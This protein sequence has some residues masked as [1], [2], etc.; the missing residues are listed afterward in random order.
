MDLFAAFDPDRCRLCGECFHRCPVLR[1]PVGEAVDEM[2]R[3]RDGRDTRAVLQRCQSCFACNLG[4]PEGAN[5]TQLILDRWSEAIRRDG[6]PARA[7][8]YVPHEEH[9]FRSYVV[10]RLPADEAAMV[11]GWADRS[12][13]AE[14]L[15]PGCNWITAPYLARTRALDGV[16]IR[17]TLADCCGETYYRMGLFDRVRQSAERLVAFVERLQV[18]RLIVPCTAGLNM[19]R[20]VM[21][22]FGVTLPAEVEHVVP[23]L[24]RRLDRGELTIR[25]RLELT[26]TIQE[27]C[28][29]KLFGQEFLD[30]P[31]AL[32]E[33]LGVRVV[34]QPLHGDRALCCGIAGGFSP[35]SAFHPAEITRATVRALT[36]ARRTGADAIATYCAGCAQ[37]LPTGQLADPRSRQPV[38]HLMELLQMALGEP[39]P[40]MAEKRRRAATVLAGVTRH[41]GP[42]LLSRRRLHL[43]PLGPWD[44]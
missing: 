36:S 6:L 11:R 40:S 18:E 42:A 5:P 2:R 38:Y 17:G 9:N 31:R 34:E 27:S 24:L 23:W 25:R 29:G 39:V 20:H 21:P 12:P 43:P 37:M 7:R 13:A 33:R 1:L 4:C 28:Y 35:S 44:P 10:A 8:Y 32:L 14:I 16:T 19:M 41:Q 26:V 3:L 15:Y 30:R 22:R